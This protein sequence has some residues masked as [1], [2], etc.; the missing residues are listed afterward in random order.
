MKTKL[1]IALLPLLSGVALAN[2]GGGH[3]MNAMWQKSMARKPLAVGAAFA[4]DGRLWRAEVKQ[5]LI[6]LSVSSDLG[7]QFMPQGKVNTEAEII[8]ADGENRPQLVFGPK[9]EIGVGWT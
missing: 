7:Q 8:A 1:A 5:G 3:D 4:P 2:S 6:E 9:G